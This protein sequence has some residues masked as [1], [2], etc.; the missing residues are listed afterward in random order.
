MLSCFSTARHTTAGENAPRRLCGRGTPLSVF[1]LYREPET[2]NIIILTQCTEPWTSI[3]SPKCSPNGTLLPAWRDETRK[4]STTRG[5]MEWD[6]KTPAMRATPLRA[7]WQWH[8]SR[9]AAGE[10]RRMP[11]YQTPIQERHHPGNHVPEHAGHMPRAVRRGQYQATAGSWLSPPWKPLLLA[12]LFA[13]LPHR[14][15]RRTKVTQRRQRIQQLRQWP[16]ILRRS[17]KTSF[18]QTAPP[19]LMAH[20]RRCGRRAAL[21]SQAWSPPESPPID[22][23]RDAWVVDMREYHMW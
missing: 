18:R 2:Q 10:H 13:R 12:S 23:W 7:Y 11:R 16:L 8:K 15:Q 6:R 3:S 21:P 17:Q 22:S 4:R 19:A 9:S 1:F 14:P 20:G 5:N